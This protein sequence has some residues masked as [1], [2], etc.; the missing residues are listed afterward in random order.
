MGI[1]R[2]PLSASSCGKYVLPPALNRVM[3]IRAL[4]PS[5]LLPPLTAVLFAHVPFS[6]FLPTSRVHHRRLF[7]SEDQTPK[8]LF[9]SLTTNPSLPHP[10][11][12]L[13]LT[14]AVLSVVAS[15]KIVLQYA[16]TGASRSGHDDALKTTPPA[17]QACSYRSSTH[18]SAALTLKQ[19][20]I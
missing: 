8:P 1:A 9:A 19:P 5:L 17:L 3:R 6:T 13:M 14:R 4:S 18:N 2:H 11:R 20:H 15:F 16:S 7:R 12:L 10:V